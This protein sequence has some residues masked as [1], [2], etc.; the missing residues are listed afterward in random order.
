MKDKAN[1]IG[2]NFGHSASSCLISG[3][4]ELKFAVEEDKLIKEKYTSRFPEKG[5]AYILNNYNLEGK[6][7]WSEGWNRYQR[8]LFKGI[9]HTCKYVLDSEYLQMRMKKEIFRFAQGISRYRKYGKFNFIGHHASHAFSLIPYGL[10]RNSLIFVSDTMG[11]ME[12]MSF[13]YWDGKLRLLKK[14]AYPHSLG[15]VYHQFAYHLGFMGRTGP[16]KLMALSGYGKPIWQEEIENICELKDGN[17]FINQNYYSS[18]RLK[19]A[20]T[21][22]ATKVKNKNFKQAL[23]ESA[24]KYEAGQDI[25]ASIQAWFTSNSWNLLLQN[26]L[27]AREKLKLK[28]DHIGLAGGSALNCQ[29][30]GYILSKLSSVDIDSLIVSPWSEDSGTSIGAA[31]GSFLY[32][33]PE[34]TV[35]KATAFLGPSATTVIQTSLNEQAIKIASQAIIEGKL[36]SLVSGKLEFGPRALGGRCIIASAFLPQS[37]QNLNACKSRP[38]FMPFAPAIL[39][40]D[41][42]A[43]FEGLGSVNMA[44]TVRAK[45]NAVSLIPS[46]IH[47]TNEA[48]VEIVKADNCLLYALLREIKFRKGIGVALLTSLNNAGETVPVFLNDARI[49]SN[50]LGLH[51]LLSDIGWEQF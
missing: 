1:Y 13:F 16:G 45:Q 26:L 6:I 37:K 10:P 33:N 2:I 21:V 32:D 18:Y 8:L 9:I 42:D 5:I 50:N 49:V 14:I 12:S 15:S 27:V 3:D 43:I 46:A 48:R 28:I 40:E 25:A 51:G 17:F 31:I 30:N 29:T 23:E 34:K 38:A 20:P 35:S 44:W 19:D 47:V 11:E 24:G 41:F 36:I 39:E 7:K 4:G 22:F